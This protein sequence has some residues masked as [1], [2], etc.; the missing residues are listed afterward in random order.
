LSEANEV[1]EAVRGGGAAV[2]D[3]SARGRVEVAGAEA[4]PFL[5]GMMT[6]DVKALADGRW[7]RAAL[8]NVQGR[9]LASTRVL[10][11]GDAF[12]FDT[13][14]PT[15]AALFK[16][17]ERFTLAGDFRVRD[18][19]TETACLTVQGRG[20]AEVVRALFGEEAASLPR[21]QVFRSDGVPRFSHPLTILRD[22]HTAEDG[23]DV[24]TG[25]ADADSLRDELARAGALSGEADVW[26]VLRVEAGAPAYGVD[27]DESNVVLEAVADEAVSFTK[28]C[29]VGQEIIARIHWRG[30]VAKRLAG[31]VFEGDGARPATGARLLA[32]DADREAGRV[33]SVA[34]SPRLGRAVALAVVK[35]DFLKP[36][37]RLRVA[38]GEGEEALA[39]EVAELPLVRGSWYE[40]AAARE[41][42]EE[43]GAG[44]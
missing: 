10:R 35:Y 25:A 9:L 40:G 16:A 26:E 13:E 28:G 32:A 2:F 17:L 6:N 21:G 30:H 38:G 39:A 27:V 7:M 1:Y 34:H 12:L 20:A 31:L 43:A 36:G 44:G 15:H 18:L 3:L 24:F 4:V 37:T 5:N 23:F 33:T 8:P 22:T 14:R 19:T 42:N 11:L 29:Y 41:S